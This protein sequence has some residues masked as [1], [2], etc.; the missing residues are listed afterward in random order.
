MGAANDGKRIAA[1]VEAIEELAKG[2]NMTVG[3]IASKVFG[4]SPERVFLAIDAAIE[5]K[6]IASN[7]DR[8]V[9]DDQAANDGE[10]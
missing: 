7:R 8:S 1:L 6:L 9:L 3:E 5:A 2:H 4:W 10:T